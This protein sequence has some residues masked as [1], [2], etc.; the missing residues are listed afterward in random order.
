MN[1]R[2]MVADVIAQQFSKDVGKFQVK[3]DDPKALKV[4]FSARVDYS[5]E[6]GYRYIDMVLYAPGNYVQVWVRDRWCVIAQDDLESD[7]D[8]ESFV[9]PGKAYAEGASAWECIGDHDSCWRDSVRDF[10]GK[11]ENDIQGFEGIGEWSAV[12]SLTSLA[13]PEKARSR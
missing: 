10:L 6:E 7:D 2:Y 11:R 5:S 3:K 13:L 8:G 4:S 12:V 1:Y 9:K